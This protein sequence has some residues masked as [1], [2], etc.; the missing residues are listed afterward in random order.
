[1]RQW[2]AS[3]T[4]IPNIGG[5]GRGISSFDLGAIH[6]QHHINKATVRVIEIPGAI[7]Q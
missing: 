7:A 3:T 1:M 5:V 4:D 6:N 2:N